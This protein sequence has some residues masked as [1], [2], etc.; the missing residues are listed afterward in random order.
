MS[1]N[2]SNI[3]KTKA[4]FNQISMKFFTG[5]LPYF[6]AS[7]FLAQATTSSDPIADFESH[8]LS[9]L[10]HELSSSTIKLIGYKKIAIPVE[11]LP[12]FNAHYTANEGT[13][14]NIPSTYYDEPAST[15]RVYFPVEAALVEHEGKLMEANH[16]GELSVNEIHGDC[17]VVGRYQ[18]DHVTGVEG[19]I[20]VNGTIYL[21]SPA[22][23]EHK[24][25]D[26]NTYVY[27][28]GEK[29]IMSH[30]HDLMSRD[31]GKV[32]CRANH[33]GENCSDKYNIHNG[34]CPRRHDTCVDYNGLFTDCKKGGSRVTNF[35][36]SDCFTSLA[37]GHCWNEIM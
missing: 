3:L 31:D 24:I 20:I 32:S 17:A 13:W 37:E 12:E 14:K 29:R 19:N 2:F 15:L 5:Y 33:G 28:F 30:G 27:D 35:P 7:F 21:S 11:E 16:L 34:R 1:Q 4:E 25:A 9:T 23:P 36:D 8:F 10:K 6:A 22:Y 18:T 26:T